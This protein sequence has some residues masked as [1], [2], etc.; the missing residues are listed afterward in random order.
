M[1]MVFSSFTSRPGSQL[2][3]I[4][5]RGQKAMSEAT[6]AAGEVLSNMRTVR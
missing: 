5:K 1:L 6:G 4:S 2:R 3:K